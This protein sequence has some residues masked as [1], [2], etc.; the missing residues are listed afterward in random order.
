[1]KELGIKVASIKNLVHSILLSP[2]DEW[3]RVILWMVYVHVL[4]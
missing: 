3:F 1:M 4:M 2:L